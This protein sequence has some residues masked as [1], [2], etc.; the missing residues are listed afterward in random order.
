MGVL[1]LVRL[2][3]VV[4]G[5]YF[6]GSFNGAII[7]SKYLLRNDIRTH[8][9]GNAGL[10][11]FFRVFGGPLTL[12]V[13]LC[14]VLKAI[15]AVLLGHFLLC[16]VD[17]FTSIGVLSKYIAGLCCML[18]HMYPCM[19]QFKGGKGVLSSVAAILVIDWRLFLV[20]IAV[21]LV[22]VILTRWVSLGSILGS[23]TFA[24]GT[25]ALYHNAVLNGWVCLF[26]LIIGALIIWRHRENLVRICQGKENRFSFHKKSDTEGTK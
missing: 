16:V 22:S 6:L 20:W 14:D 12:V 13:L 1:W 3:I 7:I 11:N 25:I 10:T 15:A 19:F 23:V 4:I 21:F 2:L 9:S 26:G 17:P 5:S 24:V 18:G 8:G